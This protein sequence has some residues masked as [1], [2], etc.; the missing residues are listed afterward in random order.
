MRADNGP[1][2]RGRWSQVTAVEGREAVRQPV[3]QLSGARI[4]N[5]KVRHAVVI[6]RQNRNARPVRRQVGRQ[7]GGAI[8]VVVVH[9]PH[10]KLA[11]ARVL[12]EQIRMAVAIEISRPHA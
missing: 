11:G 8:R 3:G 10:A 5:D 2:G 9:I 4:L 12:E 7:V 6:Q 1:I